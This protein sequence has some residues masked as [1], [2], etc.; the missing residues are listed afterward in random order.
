MR[1]V[2][3]TISTVWTTDSID[4]SKLID[5][6]LKEQPRE[7]PSVYLYFRSHLEDAWHGDLQMEVPTVK[8]EEIPC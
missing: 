3:I 1:K 4:D 7:Q 2:K 6:I 8:W 5:F